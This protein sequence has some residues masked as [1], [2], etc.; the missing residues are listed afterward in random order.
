MTQFMP[1]INSSITFAPVP[2]T[3]VPENCDTLSGAYY[4]EYTYN[5]TLLN[6]QVCMPD[7]IS[8]SPWKATR[9]RQD[10]SEQMFLNINYG[11]PVSPA[12]DDRNPSNITLKLLVNTTLGY[13]ELPNYNN[14]GI[15][16]PLL[17]KDPHDTC[18]DNDS[19]CLSQWVFR[20]SLQ[21]NESDSS[22]AI[23]R[24]ANQGPL[25][26]IAAAMFDPGSFIAT[27]L[28]Q[29]V[30]D[31]PRALI[32]GPGIPCTLA[33]LI[34]LLGDLILNPCYPETLAAD[35]GYEYVSSWLAN[36]YDTDAMGD[37]LHAAVILASQV[38]L[39]SVTGSLT[40]WYD[41][42]QDSERPKISSAGVIILSIMLAIDL[43]LLLALATYVSFSHTWTSDFNS[44]AMMR[45]GAARAEEFPLMI[46][47]REGKRETEEVLGQIPGWVGDARPDDEVGV[48][49]V[50]AIAPLRPGRK[51]WGS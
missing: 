37:A 15:A 13:F 39:T 34:L 23:G 7:D 46:S 5:E 42:G 8:V 33:P 51:Y 19:H 3:A 47:S 10:I 28:P 50:G 22:F 6:L 12:T 36:F 43:A 30:I 18:L 35:D 25:A 24:I 32:R 17:A 11:T 29:K 44:A 21:L 14:S 20:R 2:Q 48:L 40:V 16:G 4:V 1:R 27:Q 26:M 41:L 9:D 45:L 38:W 31:P 49:A